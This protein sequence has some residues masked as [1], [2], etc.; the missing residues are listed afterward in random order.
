ML[1]ILIIIVFVV[2][3]SLEDTSAKELEKDK[4]T[5]ERIMGRKYD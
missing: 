2:I 5:Y 1:F 3:F 4:K